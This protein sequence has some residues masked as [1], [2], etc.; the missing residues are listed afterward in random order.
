MAACE[1]CGSYAFFGS[2]APESCPFC[3][4][5][6][7]KAPSFPAFDIDVY[8]CPCGHSYGDHDYGRHANGDMKINHCTQC[9][10]DDKR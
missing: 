1:T 6:E 10:E 4:R 3:A 9:R 7:C 8:D 2:A 5:A